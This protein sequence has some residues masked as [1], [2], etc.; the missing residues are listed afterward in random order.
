[1]WYLTTSCGEVVLRI[2]HNPA[3]ARRWLQRRDGVQAIQPDLP[4]GVVH[5]YFQILLQSLLGIAPGVGGERL[6][7]ESQPVRSPTRNQ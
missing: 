2:K 6:R 3:E 4:A 5:T 7:V 1:M